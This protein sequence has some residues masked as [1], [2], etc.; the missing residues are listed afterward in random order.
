MKFHIKNILFDDYEETV[1]M[2]FR[3][4]NCTNIAFHCKILFFGISEVKKN[5][6]STT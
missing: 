6:N 5:R 3:L 4:F 1:L 2:A